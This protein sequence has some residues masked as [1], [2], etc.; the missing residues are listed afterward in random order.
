VSELTARLRA[1]LTAARKSQNKP[2]TLLLGTI[3]ADI[4]NRALEQPG[5]LAEGAVVEVIQRGI[6]RRREA[7]E[8]YAKAGRPEL[9]AKE[10]AEVAGL[11]SYLPA[12]A[13][14]DEIRA[15]VREAI[16]QG[17]AAMGAVMGRVLPR[18][19]GTAD[20]A[21]VSTIARDELAKRAP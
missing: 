10:T 8:I 14:D 21:R 9:A 2:L 20:R 7:A 11:E 19:Q 17:A 5:A 4:A 15:A 3:L 12:R 13:S 18:F 1:D 16:A 6:R